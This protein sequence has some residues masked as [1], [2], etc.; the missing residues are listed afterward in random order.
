M[1]LK[2]AASRTLTFGGHKDFV[3]GLDGLD[4]FFEVVWV[5]GRYV[6]DG[7]P[8][9]NLQFGR[10]YVLIIQAATNGVDSGYGRSVFSV[11]PLWGGLHYFPV[12]VVDNVVVRLVEE[13]DI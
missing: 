2:S 13:E 3:C 7:L 10:S 12:W 6:P 5:V 1:A 9:R 4:G 8:F 11:L